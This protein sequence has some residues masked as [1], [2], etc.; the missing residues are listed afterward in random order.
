MLVATLVSV[1]LSFIIVFKFCEAL[2]YFELT[3]FIDS[4]YNIW[5]H[6][7]E[8][9]LSAYIIKFPVHAIKI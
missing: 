7:R 8:K 5:G 4:V 2:M 1:P 9:G 3:V 6:F